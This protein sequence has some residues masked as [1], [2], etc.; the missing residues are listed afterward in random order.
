M[1]F[2][3]VDFSASSYVWTAELDVLVGTEMGTLGVKSTWAI[4]FAIR[5]FI[6]IFDN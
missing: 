2:G 4:T 1:G 6:R 3:K 5:R